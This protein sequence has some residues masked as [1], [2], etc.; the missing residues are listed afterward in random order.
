MA[1][2]CAD[3][4][5]R[6]R[7]VRHADR[8]RPTRHRASRPSVAVA[9][10]LVASLAAPAA[11]DYAQVAPIL[12]TRCV[13]CHQGEAAPLGL[14]LDTLDG[15]RAGSSNG[16]VV[17]AGDAQ[18]SELM[19]RLRGT[20]M[21]RMPMT[22]PPFLS[23][24]E[25]VLFEQWILGGLVP[26]PGTGSAKQAQA[27]RPRPAAGEPVTYAHVAPILATRC[28]KC[29]AATG[30]MGPA[31]EG[32]LLTSHAA[33]VGSVER[34][35]VV[36][37]RPEASELMRRLRGQALPRMP[38]DG[39]PYLDEEELA[40]VESWIRDGARD[41]NGVAAPVPVGARLR[42]HGTLTGRWQL[43]G[44]SLRPDA[45]V[46]VDK[47]PG[48]GDYVEVRGRVAGDGGVEVER[49]RRR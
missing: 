31:P 9:L 38:F 46:R 26:G 12:A 15:V 4:S 2:T 30:L 11:V 43:D 6:P 40:L 16:P 48:A 5:H 33:T 45:G 19:R 37:G 39:P 41:G 20:S 29:H 36:P 32:L 17:L 47:S 24:E 23:D 34:A 1:A 22:G 10:L 49:L 14:R 44:L 21:P 8:L 42:L 35:R 25:I 13:M 3:A 28:A 27:A 18:G 7:A